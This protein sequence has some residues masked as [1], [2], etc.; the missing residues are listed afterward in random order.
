MSEYLR[1]S[2]RYINLLY[3]SPLR[4]VGLLQPTS[5]TLFIEYEKP[6]TMHAEIKTQ[7]AS[8]K[9]TAKSA[10]NCTPERRGF[11]AVPLITTQHRFP[12]QPILRPVEAEGH[13][14]GYYETH[15]NTE[16]TKAQ[17]S[18]AR[19]FEEVAGAAHELVEE[20]CRAI[21]AV[22]RAVATLFRLSVRAVTL[23]LAIACLTL[24]VGIWAWNVGKGFWSRTFA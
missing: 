17:A 23:T 16:T 18:V 10:V 15:S 14:Y 4:P 12:T 1:S 13:E 24:A 21:E 2:R 11:H 6:E 7:F 3:S 9:R 8:R 22:S 5:I 19:C 20:V